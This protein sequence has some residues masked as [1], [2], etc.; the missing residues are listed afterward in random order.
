MKLFVQVLIPLSV[1]VAF[2]LAVPSSGDEAQKTEALRLNERS[3]GD[4]GDH[5]SLQGIVS[6][7]KCFA[8]V[9]MQ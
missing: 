1:F 3:E 9:Y 7:Y 8:G 4:N 2:A 6:L 5:I